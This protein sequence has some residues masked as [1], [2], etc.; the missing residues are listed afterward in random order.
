MVICTE[1]KPKKKR[2]PRE[3]SSTAEPVEPRR[4]TRLSHHKP[5]EVHARRKN[6][7][8]MVKLQFSFSHISFNSLM[9]CAGR[10]CVHLACG[11]LRVQS[12]CPQ[13]PFMEIGHEIISMAILSIPLIQVGQLS[14]TGKRMCT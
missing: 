12:S 3:R 2:R 13:H 7:E 11:W 9:P 6:K 14:V 4:S 8:H 1:P 5:L 10:M